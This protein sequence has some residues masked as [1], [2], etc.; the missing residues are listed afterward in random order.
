[1]IEAAAPAVNGNLNVR[2][3]SGVVSVHLDGTTGF[4]G[5]MHGEFGRAGV[6]G[7][8]TA[9]DALGITRASLDG[10]TGVGSFEVLSVGTQANV[11]TNLLVGGAASI[12]AGLQ[13][14]G[15]TTL[16]GNLNVNNNNV[17]NAS[18]VHTTALRGVGANRFA[19]KVLLSNFTGSSTTISN[20][21]IGVGSVVIAQIESSVGGTGRFVTQAVPTAGQF[22]AHFNAP[23]ANENVVLSYIVVNP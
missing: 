5:A 1:M 6:A 20:S 13:V 7:L 22:T 15:V 17:L 9:R 21:L 16:G 12:S 14:T 10:A 19:H 4:V 18:S 3:A 11:G 2:N 23:F 8:V